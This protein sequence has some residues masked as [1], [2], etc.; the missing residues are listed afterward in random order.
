MDSMMIQSIN[1][2]IEDLNKKSNHLDLTDIYTRDYTFFSSEH[3]TFSRIDHMFIHKTI[4]INFN[5]W[6]NTNYL[7]LQWN[8]A[9]HQ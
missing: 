4:L 3:G 2:E 1:K 8:E 6:N 5:M 7:Q 9:N